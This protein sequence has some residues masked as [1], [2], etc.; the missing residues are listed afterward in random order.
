MPFDGEVG[1][2]AGIDVEHLVVLHQLKGKYTIPLADSH[3]QG[4]DEYL[5]ALAEFTQTVDGN[6]TCY[7]LYDV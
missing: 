3:Q 2:H 6:K 1:I 4:C 5:R 7:Q